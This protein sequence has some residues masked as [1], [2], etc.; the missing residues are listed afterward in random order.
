MWLF[1]RTLVYGKRDLPEAHRIEDGYK[2]IPLGAFE[3]VGVAYEPPKP[4]KIV[5]TPRIP[6]LP[7]G[8][9][10]YDALGDALAKNPPPARDHAILAEMATAG[11]GPGLHPSAESL[12]SSTIAGLTAAANSG[13]AEVLSIRLST[14]TAGAK[15]HNGWFQL[16]PDTGNWGTDYSY[17]AMIAVYAICANLPVE[18]RTRPEWPTTPTPSSRARTATGSTSPPRRSRPVKYFWS[19]T[20]YDT[21]TELIANP[22]AKYSIGSNKGVKYNK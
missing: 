13:P 12:S 7:T 9:A 17:R 8:L 16:L 20:I 22:F 1:G 18:R 21:N 2:A 11:V 19:L 10:F 4:R 14:A 5:T 3:R 15:K 6:K